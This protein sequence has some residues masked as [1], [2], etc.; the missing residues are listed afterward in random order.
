VTQAITVEPATTK[1]PRYAVIELIYDRDCAN[2]TDEG[3]W[4]VI[5]FSDDNKTTH[6]PKDSLYFM[7]L[8]WRQRFKYATAF[9][10]NYT[11]HGLCEWSLYDTKNVQHYI[12]Q[13]WVDERF[14]GVLRWVGDCK[15]LPKDKVK[16]YKMAEAFI[17]TYTN[18]C[19]GSCYAFQ[20]RVEH[21]GEQDDAWHGTY[22]GDDGM[23]D[24]IQGEL[25]ALLK[26]H[27]TIER[28]FVTGSMRWLGSYLS[29]KLPKG[30]EIHKDVKDI[31]HGVEFYFDL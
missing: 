7:G 23:E 4:E 6:K 5:S 30:V 27:P 18:W 24:D 22:Y 9:R 1:K 10:L 31:E 8:G 26:K 14:D 19:N 21:G 11:E 12:N 15:Y 13:A 3:E 17:E 28:V 16:R 29:L 2:P 25:D 20:I